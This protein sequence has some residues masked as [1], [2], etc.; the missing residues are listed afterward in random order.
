MCF[1]ISK[2]TKFAVADKDIVCQKIIQYNPKHQHYTGFIATDHI[3]EIG[4]TYTAAKPLT[5]KEA[6]KII[7][8]A[9]IPN[10]L[11]KLFNITVNNELSSEV[12]YA[13]KL[14]DKT[15]KVDDEIIETK[16]ELLKGLLYNAKT[17]SPNVAVLAEFIIPKGTWYMYNY[18]N[19][20]I[21]TIVA[22][23]MKFNRVIP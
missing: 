22:P 6:R 11:R 16:E 21:K 7:K 2:N 17:F 13:L 3:Y 4:K 1:T 23:K 19:S 20:I 8:K 12:I 9:R 14:T 5:E 18:P 15:I 10:L